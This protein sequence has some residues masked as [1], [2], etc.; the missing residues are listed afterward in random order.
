MRL[1]LTHKPVSGL[2]GTFG[3]QHVQSDFSAVGEEAF[4]PES[5]TTNTGLFLY[6]TLRLGRV[7]LEAAARQEWQTIK[8]AGE[9]RAEHNPF[10][11]SGAAMWESGDGYSVALSLARSQRAPNAQELFARGFTW[12]PTPT[13]LAMPH[14]ARKQRTRST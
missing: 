6:E 10:S 2:H 13:S 14:L 9:R 1:E 3:V 5:K 4:L 12:R 7:R 8:A 11:L